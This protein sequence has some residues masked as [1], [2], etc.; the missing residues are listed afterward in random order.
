MIG[1]KLVTAKTKIPGGELLFYVTLPSVN[2]H[3]L[4]VADPNR[5]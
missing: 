1:V 2:N 5:S 4:C 3:Y